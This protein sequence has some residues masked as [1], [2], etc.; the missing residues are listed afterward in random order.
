MMEKREKAREKYKPNPIEVLFIAE[1]PPGDDDRFF[2]YEDVKAHDWLYLGLMKIL[3]GVRE[4]STLRQMKKDYLACFCEHGFYLMD[5]CKKSMPRGARTN[6]KK[7]I[8]TAA[9]DELIESL[10]ELEQSS[11]FSKSTPVILIAAP[12]FSA[13]QDALKSAGYNILNNR[14]VYFPST[15]WINSYEQEMRPLLDDLGWR[16]PRV[17]EAC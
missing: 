2:Y 17:L 9:L 15:R 12:V 14:A 3:Y 5:A 7:R 1:A 4:T 13:C 10:K 16:P 11:Q 8:L 6:E